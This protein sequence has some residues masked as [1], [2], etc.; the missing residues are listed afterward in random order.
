MHGVLIMSSFHELCTRKNMRKSVSFFL[1]LCREL[2]YLGVV[3]Y[4]V[5]VHCMSSVH[6]WDFPNRM[7]VSC[8]CLLP[9]WESQNFH[10][11]WKDPR[12]RAPN[13]LLQ[14]NGADLFETIKMGQM[15]FLHMH[16]T[17]YLASL[18]QPWGSAITFHLVSG[19][20]LNYLEFRK[21]CYCVLSY[22]S[23]WQPQTCVKP[24]A[25]NTV[26]ELLMMSDVS[27][28][29]CWAIKNVEIINSNAWLHIVGYFK[30]IYTS[31]SQPPGRGPIPYPGI[32]YT[33][34]REVLLE[35]VILVF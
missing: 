15:G 5:P 23:G 7:T 9:P 14:G 33:G 30:M 13:T 12:H 26:F 24:E 35:V 18:C 27:L 29:T 2:C 10:M 28:E 34:P 11:T 31:V 25:A 3:N 32:N 20:I 1:S 4:R 21:C 8:R 22:D 6:W 16:H 19:L 17:W